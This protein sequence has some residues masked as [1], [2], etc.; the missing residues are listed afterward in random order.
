MSI[1]IRLKSIALATDGGP[2]RHQFV[3]PLTVLTGPVGVGKSTLFELAKYAIGGKAR[4]APVARDHITQVQ[5]ELE[6]ADETL[7]LTRAL[8]GA[9]ASQVEIHDVRAGETLGLFQVKPDRSGDATRT[10]SSALLGAMGLP[11][12][13]VATSK[14]RTTRITFNNVWSFIYVE[15]R[16]IDRSV[17]RN[18]DTYSEPARKTTF[19]LLF[20]LT[21]PNV[22][23]LREQELKAQ[24]AL[25]AAQ[26]DERAV[27]AFL[28][29]SRTRTQPEATAAAEAA[30]QSR[31][32]AAEQLA[33]LQQEA[34]TVRGQVGVVRDLVLQA[35]EQLAELQSEQRELAV[36]NDEQSRLLKQL[37]DRAA[38]ADRATQAATI[39]GPI[40]FVICPRCAQSITSRSHDEGTCRLCLQPEPVQNAEDAPASTA[41]ADRVASQIDEVQTLLEFTTSE[42]SAVDSR[43]LVAREN[44]A[45]L[46]ALLDERTRN[47]V[48]PRLEQYA[49]AAAA[50]ARSETMLASMEDVLRQWDR[51]NDLKLARVSA[52]N[53]LDE[54]KSALKAAQDSLES[55]RTQLLT[56]LSA[57][58]QEIVTRLG[59]P[60][61][62]HAEIDP[63]SYLPFANGDRFDK[64]STGGITTGLVTAYWLTVLATALRERQTNYPTLLIIDTPRKSIGAQNARMADELYRQLDTLASEYGDRMQVIV[65]DNDVPKDISKR[66][67]DLRFDYDHPTVPTVPHPGPAGVTPID[68]DE[69]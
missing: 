69:D 39:L 14:T 60:T 58:Y 28:A 19:E 47:F 8:A 31:L 52:E 61:V 48:S 63:K 21:D 10:V 45:K 1:R 38:E 2:V 11:T 3:G 6:I 68:R 23:K 20:G 46:E 29:D 49:D 7:R 24:G 35:R 64:I 54:A 53:K 4:I 66:W 57:D 37:R 62:K 25:D 67:Q 36:A 26:V 18:N 9:T 41:E 27:T 12:D 65:A 13:V 32:A 33:S 15:Q 30:E 34:D 40:E 55:V 51:A 50:L 5:I 43:L 22:L 17:A 59:V 16:E 44:L 56:A 42:R